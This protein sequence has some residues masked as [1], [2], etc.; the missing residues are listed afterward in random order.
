MNTLLYVS[1]L[2]LDMSGHR[3]D[4]D[5]SNAHD[6]L[7]VIYCLVGLG[8]FALFFLGSG[9]FSKDTDKELKI[10]GCLAIIGVVACIIVLI[11]MCSH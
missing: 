6:Y 10:W 11:N 9:A 1:S 2:L 7:L 4:T 8:L 3:A 5:N